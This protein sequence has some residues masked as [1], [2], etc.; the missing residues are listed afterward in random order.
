MRIKKI[1]A[2]FFTTIFTINFSIKNSYA[3]DLYS[4]DYILSQEEEFFMNEYKGNGIDDFKYKLGS[5]PI[6]I[7][8]PHSVKQWRNEAYKAA[9]VYT[10]AMIKTLGETTGAHIIYKTSTN[11]DENYTT[12]ETEY[13]KMISKIV[14]ENNIRVVFDLHGMSIDKESDIDIGTGNTKNINLLNQDYILSSIQSSL[15][16]SNYTVNKYF[17]GGSAYTISNYASQKLGIPTVQLEVNRKFRST[18]SEDFTYM[19]NLLTEMINDINDKCSKVKVESLKASNI[20]TSS[21][22]LLWDKIPGIS[23]YE[24]YRS[25]SKSGTYEKIITTENTSYTDSKLASGKTYYYKVKAVG[26]DMSSILAESTLCDMPTVKLSAKESKTIEVSWNKVNGA[27]GYEIYR[28]TSKAG[29]YSKVKTITSGSTLNFTDTKV[30]TGQTYYYKVR[31]YK[32]VNGG[33]VYGNYSSI[34]SISAKLSTPSISLSAGNKK[35]YIKWNKV[36]DASGYEIYRATSKSGKYSKVTTITKGSTVSYTNSKLA[37]KKTYY[38]KIR[39]YKTIN[40]K[41]VYSSYSTVKSIKT[42]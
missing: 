14:K 10:G 20:T 21:I 34:V 16:S 25:T 2:L 23:T 40:G 36:T 13:R 7:S 27:S 29:S 15:N 38:Y 30:T 12:D 37:S 19:V 11:G 3:D 5:I 32:T 41:K 42:K 9:D 22:K 18:N 26:G 6:L 4:K 1:I 35:V 28:A 39:A 24:I 31:A 17:T 33:K 8:A